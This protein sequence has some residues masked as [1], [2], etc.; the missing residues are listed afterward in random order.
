MQKWFDTFE[1]YFEYFIVVVFFV[2]LIPTMYR[3][4]EF[5]LTK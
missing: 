4:I 2:T 5:L 1:K 3:I